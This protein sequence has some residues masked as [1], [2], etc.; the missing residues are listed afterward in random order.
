M[1]F[2]KNGETYRMLLRDRGS[3]AITIHTAQFSQYGDVLC[4]E[5]MIRNR[6]ELIP[7]HNVVS[8]S[9]ADGKSILDIYRQEE[10][11]APF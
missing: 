5:G 4:F 9:R 2:L 8:V 3:I 11:D 6:L 10:A 7:W 1:S